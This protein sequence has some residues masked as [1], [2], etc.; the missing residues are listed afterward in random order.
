MARLQ[1]IAEQ[2]RKQA[3]NDE[4]AAPGAA[5]QST[6]AGAASNASTQ[7]V[8]RALPK[9][10][11]AA[12]MFSPVQRRHDRRHTLA[13]TVPA[14]SC[15]RSPLQD[16]VAQSHAEQ[17]SDCWQQAP[18]ADGASSVLGDSPACFAPESEHDWPASAGPLV[19]ASEA[20]SLAAPSSPPAS[21]QDERSVSPAK[22]RPAQPP[23]AA[24]VPAN[25]PASA[26]ERGVASRTRRKTGGA[27]LLRAKHEESS[28]PAKAVRTRAPAPAEPAGTLTAP[29]KPQAATGKVQKVLSLV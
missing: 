27:E 4:N 14:A 5:D 18:D 3:D 1:H 22:Q 19:P 25:M 9:W 20:G 12:A 28:K 2:E 24:P 6:Q 8:F 17:A 11:E 21:A 23:C 15:S 10:D 16:F 7:P 13:P 29:S 26:A